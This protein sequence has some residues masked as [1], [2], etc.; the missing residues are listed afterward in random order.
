MNNFYE[1]YIYGIHEVVYVSA[2]S[3]LTLADLIIFRR[4]KSYPARVG[5]LFSNF[6]GIDKKKILIKLPL[7][8]Y[9]NKHL[10]RMLCINQKKSSVQCDN[11][12]FFYSLVQKFL[13]QLLEASLD[14]F[15]CNEIKRFTDASNQ[16]ELTT[17]EKAVKKII[18]SKYVRTQ[19]KTEYFLS[20][21]DFSD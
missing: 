8:H 17:N 5:T 15:E 14:N 11:T 20:T 21:S 7:P 19:Y 10:S 18:Y 2:S 1:G 16:T 4:C 13:F 6:Q 9:W 12:K 3:P